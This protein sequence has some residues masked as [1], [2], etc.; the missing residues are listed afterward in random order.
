MKGIYTLFGTVS[1]KDIELIGKAKSIFKY[2]TVA[3]QLPQGAHGLHYKEDISQLRAATR[4]I[5]GLAI[6]FFREGKGHLES[7]LNRSYADSWIVPR[8]I[9]AD[10]VAETDFPKYYI[11]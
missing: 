7:F 8:S 3:I 1:E 11:N 4:D 2:V 5:H 10:L 9:P 6:D